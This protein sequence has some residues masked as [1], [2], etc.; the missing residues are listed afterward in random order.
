MSG[1][2]PHWDLPAIKLLARA[3]KWTAIQKWLNLVEECYAQLGYCP[4]FLSTKYQRPEL[5][6]HHGA[7]WNLNCAAGW[8]QAL[9]HSVIGIEFHPDGIICHPAPLTPDASLKKMTFPS[10]RWTI[11]K[12][13][14]GEFIAWLEI[15]GEKITNTLKIP[16]K[17][18]TAGEHRLTIHYQSSEPDEPILK[19]LI[20]AEL[21]EVQVE[22]NGNR[23]LILGLGTAEVSFSCSEKP[24]I[25]LDGNPIAF[26]WADEQQNG[27]LKVILN[28]KHQFKIQRE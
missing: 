4:E 13:G 21:L 11:Q 18:Y 3:R 24:V 6:Q 5:W 7:A 17:F 25:L 8:Y 12:S 14:E 27:K 10:G 16:A 15:D 9:I 1:W 23:Y 19:E 26:H 2:Y 20:G 28:G 22:K